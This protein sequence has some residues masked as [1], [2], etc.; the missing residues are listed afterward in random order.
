M[1]GEPFLYPGAV[2]ALIRNY[3]NGRAGARRMPEQIL[4]AREEEVLKLMP[5]VTPRREIAGPWHQRQD[6]R[7][8]PGEH[9]RRNSACATAWN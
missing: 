1:R 7:A 9:A 8:A 3:L 5:R 6:R 4:T 2:T